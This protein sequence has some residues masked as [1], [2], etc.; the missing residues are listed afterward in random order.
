[1]NEEREGRKSSSEKLTISASSR[2]G[3]MARPRGGPSNSGVVGEAAREGG[4]GGAEGKNR[5]GGAE[6]KNRGGGGAS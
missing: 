3:A 2:A 4:G 6:G 1:V 5:C